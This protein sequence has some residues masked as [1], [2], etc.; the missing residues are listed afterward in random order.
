M[1]DIDRI[2]ITLADDYAE[3]MGKALRDLEMAKDR[4]RMIEIQAEGVRAIDYSKP[5]VQSS[6]TDDAMQRAFEAM[7]AAREKVSETMERYA[8]MVREFE[9]TIER[10]E[11]EEYRFLLR[12]HYLGKVEHGEVV[13]KDWGDIARMMNYSYSHVSGSLR[14]GALLSLYEV[15]PE[16]CRIPEAI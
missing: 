12:M 7:E 3:Q 10:I 8:S 14:D 9:D 13:R 16:D 5:R 15:M 1:C 2:R 4:V 11:R 6:P